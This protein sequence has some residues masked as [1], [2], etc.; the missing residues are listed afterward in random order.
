MRR[1]FPFAR[2]EKRCLN[3]NRRSPLLDRLEERV[4][5][6]TMNP[7]SVSLGVGSALDLS[8]TQTLPLSI[9]LPPAA[10]SDKVDIALL[11][12]DT[13]SFVQFAQTIEQEFKSLV[14]ALQAALPGVDFGF[15]VARM[16]DYGGPGTYFSQDTLQA[17]PFTLDQPIVT[18]ATATAHGT[19]LNALMASA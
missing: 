10:V 8:K 7:T 6:S 13:G 2:A 4:Q 9:T 15:G 1:V 3:R 16:A 11:I 19:T 12:D 5:L 18:S 14:G 17:R